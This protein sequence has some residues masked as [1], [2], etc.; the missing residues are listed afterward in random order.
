MKTNSLQINIPKDWKVSKLGDIFDISNGL[1]I[2]KSEN[3]ELCNVL[4]NT[5]FSN[6]GYID[7][8]DIANLK[9][10]TKSLLSRTLKLGDIIIEKSGGS[11]T[12]PVGRVVYFNITNG[13]YS[14][15]NFTS[16]LRTKKDYFPKFYFYFLYNFWLK[17]GTRELQR[18]TTGIRNLDFNSYQNLFLP[19][20]NI[21]EQKK[22]ANILSTVDEE[23]Q[24]IRNLILQTEKIKEGLMRDIFTKGIGHT[25]FKKTKIGNL[26]DK[27]DTVLLG[28]VANRGS[29]HTPNK[30]HPEYWNGGIKWVSLSD[31]K[32]LNNRYLYETDKEISLEGIENS[33]AVL[34]PKDTV[35]ICRDAGIGKVGILGMNNMAVSQHFI[36]WQCSEKLNYVY[37][38]YLLQS[39]QKRFE[40]IATGTT[41]KT[42]GLPFFKELI[43]PLPDIDEQK[44]IGDILWLID[45]KIQVTRRL[46]T[47]LTKLKKGLMSDL[48]SGKV[49][50]IK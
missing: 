21:C 34:H 47:K 9:V 36:A 43:I 27:W 4:R 37:L 31:S 19:V 13:V 46:N 8:E 23:I 15:S 16:C 25:K 42:I 6:N 3:T 17:G 35:I 39:W 14:F 41:I 5:N 49:R 2:G 20:P 38:Y 44:K 48:L 12:Q 11:D 26:P 10:D 33:S 7:T 32:K 1:W 22:I 40:R 50:T 29:G 28:S 45:N 30:Q 18:Q 24:K